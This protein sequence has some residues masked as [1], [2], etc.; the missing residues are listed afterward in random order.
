MR[1]VGLSPSNSNA[2]ERAIVIHANAYMED[3]FIRAHGVP[4]RSYGC[5]V[6]ARAD[7][8]RVIEQLQGGALIFA[9]RQPERSV[10]R[11]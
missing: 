2:E 11:N 7:R 6:L 1:L 4:G 10:T 5:L 3:A 8:D 9:I